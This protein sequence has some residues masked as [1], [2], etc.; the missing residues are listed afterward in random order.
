VPRLT[1]N[2]QDEAPRD[3]IYIDI[4]TGEAQDDP[5][6][7]GLALRYPVRV[8]QLVELDPARHFLQIE[9]LDAALRDRPRATLVAY[10]AFDKAVL[11]KVC[12]A[13]GISWPAWLLDRRWFDACAW[14]RRSIALPL[15]AFTLK[16]VAQW[17]GF[18]WRDPAVDGRLVG[19]LYA[20][21][22]RGGPPFDVDLIKKYNVDD[23]AALIYVVER[24]RRRIAVGEA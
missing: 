9:R 13:H 4:E 6:L 16:A 14:I 22:R 17:L 23:L 15:E 5:W 21:R 2:A 18:R 24:L 3:A 8:R 19:A 1:E 7:V 10:G 12:N 20:A 11:R